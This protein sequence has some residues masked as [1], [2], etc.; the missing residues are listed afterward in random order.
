[1]KKA[2]LLLV[3]W[4]GWAAYAQDMEWNKCIGGSLNDFGTTIR[5]RGDTNLIFFGSTYSTNGDVKGNHGQKDAWLLTLNTA[6]DIVRQRCIGGSYDDEGNSLQLLPGGRLLV[7]VTTE[8][9]DGDIA[10]HKGGSDMWIAQLSKEGAI[11]WQQTLG[12]SYGEGLHTVIPTADSGYLAVGYTFSNDGDVSGLHGPENYVSDAWIVKLNKHREVQWQ[13]CFG[14]TD[15]D[16]AY[17]AVALDNGDLVVAATCNSR[18]FDVT[19]T[20]GNR[21]IWLIKYD[22]AGNQL[23]KKN[24]GG[25]YDEGVFS[26]ARTRD[27]GLIVCGYSYSSDGDLTGHYKGTTSTDFEDGWVFYTDADGNLLW[28]KNLGGTG[29]DIFNHVTV[30]EDGFLLT[31]ETNS[32]DGDVGG[33]RGYKDY[34]LVKIDEAGNTVWQQTR[35]SSSFDFG[36]AS[37]VLA[38][39]AIVVNGTITAS[40]G[41]V[42]CTK[43]NTNAWL[44]K[45][46]PA[47]LANIFLQVHAAAQPAGVLLTWSATNTGHNAFFTIEKSRDAVHFGATGTVAVSQPA[48]STHRYAFTDK[49][50]FTGAAY[51]RLKLT[52]ADGAWV[53]SNIVAVT[54]AAPASMIVQPNPAP[55]GKFLVD[56]G[57]M[58]KNISLVITNGRGATVYRKQIASG[59]V[60]SILLHQPAG[61]YYIQVHFDGGKQW[62]K[63]LLK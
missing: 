44:V 33:T 20:K 59:A 21:D 7:G 58:K 5:N 57:E 32:Q 17:D 14:G 61:M 34:W 53:Y 19:N 41:D 39:G 29:S 52:N 15:S 48:P 63:I 6:G 4:H 13:T 28:Q 16:G 26:I 1:M 38:D 30:V 9:G 50:P 54:T 43:S 10:G 3:V 12:G 56:L 45:L 24:Y 60:V 49:H 35:G 46:T 31:G 42:E 40:G 37:C 22:S 62:G 51:Y 18:D 2:F 8:S 27:N 11:D 25:S 55:N 36:N 23:W 47:V